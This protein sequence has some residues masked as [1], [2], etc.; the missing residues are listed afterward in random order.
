MRQLW[1]VGTEALGFVVYGEEDELQSS[2]ENVSANT[3]SETDEE[4]SD[5]KQV[6]ETKEKQ[7][8]M[9]Y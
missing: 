8:K 3:S 4:E 9:H 1:Q 6:G 5:V 2:S 7:E